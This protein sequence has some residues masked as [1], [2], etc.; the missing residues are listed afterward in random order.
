MVT[1]RCESEV[2]IVSRQNKMHFN[3]QV[4][5]GKGE[6]IICGPLFEDTM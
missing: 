5:E 1:Q 3:I 2:G 4:L 6:V